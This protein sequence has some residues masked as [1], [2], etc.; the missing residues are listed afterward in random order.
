MNKKALTETD[1][2]ARLINKC[3]KLTAII[4]QLV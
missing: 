2:R 4:D 1:N 3:G